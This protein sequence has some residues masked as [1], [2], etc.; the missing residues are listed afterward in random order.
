[1]Q[2]V[3]AGTIAAGIEAFLKS[4]EF[5]SLASS[6]L[7]LY[8]RHGLA[9]IQAY[10]RG[11][12]TTLKTVHIRKDLATLE[13]HPSNV[14]LR[15]WRKACRWWV[16]RGWIEMNPARDVERT[17]TPKAVGAKPWTRADF[18]EFRAHWPIGTPERLTF[19][20]L[21]Q[22]CAAIG[23][24]ARLG[25]GNLRDGWLVYRRQKTGTEG[26]SPIV[27]PPPW[28][29]ANISDLMACLHDAPKHTVFLTTRHG[30]ARSAKSA[31]QWFSAA[32]TKAGLS[33]LSAHGV[34]KGRAA[35]FKEN[36]AST[37]QRMAILGHETEE[38]ATHY[39]RSADLK[40]IVLGT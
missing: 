17:P 13:A 1:R 24:V 32:C 18:A 10:G 21:Y 12:L 40:R 23:D 28:L 5:K 37:A 11:T 36:G 9:I 15:V 6:T 31:A 20:L 3:E 19:E 38:E 16:R 14:R 8:E 25:P 7:Q 35:C 4:P 30:A 26:V 39:A 34:R 22:T 27:N 33:H 29:E 2:G